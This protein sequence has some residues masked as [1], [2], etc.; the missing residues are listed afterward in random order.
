MLTRVRRVCGTPQV[1]MGNPRVLCLDEITT[2]LDSTTAFE[3]LLA[4]RV[5]AT[6][7]G[8]TV[9]ATLLQV[10]TEQNRAA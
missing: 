5:W 2:G 6:G 10:C 3:I 9:I 4:L 1:Q 8:G 7:T